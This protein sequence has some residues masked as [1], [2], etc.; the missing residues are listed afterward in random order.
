MSFHNPYNLGPRPPIQP[1]KQPIE[2]MLA[3]VALKELC[4]KGTVSEMIY[5]LKSS[6]K[7]NVWAN[8]EKQAD[9]LLKKEFMG[10]L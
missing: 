3:K 4:V 9:L 2:I 6:I 10:I 1:K 5:T 8:L 7:Q